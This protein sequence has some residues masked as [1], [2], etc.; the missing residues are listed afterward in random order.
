MAALIAVTIGIGA[1]K[2]GRIISEKRLEHK[3]KKAAQSRR[4]LIW[5]CCGADQAFIEAAGEDR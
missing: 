5:S 4:V 2:L 3:D 1:E